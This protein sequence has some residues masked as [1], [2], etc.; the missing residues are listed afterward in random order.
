MTVDL[1]VC[2][3]EASIDFALVDGDTGLEFDYSVAAGDEIL[4]SYGCESGSSSSAAAA[5]EGGEAR[6]PK[7]AAA[8][9]A[10]YGFVPEAVPVDGGR[11]SNIG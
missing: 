1:N 10:E 9:F 5:S 7:S 6:T 3:D 2:G 8:L 4:I 11:C